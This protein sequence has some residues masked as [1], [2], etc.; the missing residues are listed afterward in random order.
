MDQ[1]SLFDRQEGKGSAEWGA[2]DAVQG[3]RSGMF[4]VV[5]PI[6]QQ[7]RYANVVHIRRYRKPHQLF[8]KP[9]H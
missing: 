4:R 3:D 6:P 5:S 2:F 7:P 9:A 8:P 1:L